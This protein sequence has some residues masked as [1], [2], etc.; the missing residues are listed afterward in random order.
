MQKLVSRSEFARIAGVNPS[1]VTRLSE[2]QLKAAVY[3]KRIDVAHPAA[4]AYLERQERAQ[5]P[6]AATGLDPLYEDA[7]AWCSESGRYAPSAIQRALRIGYNRACG[8]LQMMTAA[9]LVPEKDKPATPPSSV[10]KARPEPV[11]FTTDGDGNAVIRIDTDAP[12]PRGQAAV[13]AAKKAAAADE[14]VFEV[15]EDI[16]AFAD[17]TL[18][19]L[20]EKFGTDARFVDWLKATQT[21]EAINEK[22]LKNAQTKGELVSRQLVKVGVIEPIDSAHIKLLTDG[23]KTIARRATAMHDAGR[24]LEEIEKFVADQITSFIRPVKAKVARALKDA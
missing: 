13:K 1:T 8:I 5:T 20:V 24:E 18:R 4:V 16:Q 22:R 11:T 23:A 2:T 17:M 6:A 15:P 3:G 9:G 14:I 19:E 10:T 7:V 12:K 21:I